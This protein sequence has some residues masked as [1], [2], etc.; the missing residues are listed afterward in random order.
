V[1]RLGAAGGFPTQT[2]GNLLS[3]TLFFAVA[4]SLTCAGLGPKFGNVRPFVVSC[5][6]YFCALI[7][8]SQAADLTFYALGACLVTYS[9][10]MGLP[11]AVARVA[12]LDEDGRY[13]VL[14]VPAI[15]IGAMIGPPI[16][17]VLVADDSLAPILGFGAGAV[18]LA[19]LLV[20]VAHRRQARV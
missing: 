19:L 20:G 11:F 4:G 5:G 9:F 8:L 2:V 14:T 18:L 10:G 6:I 3:A 12:E 15:G 17:G 7:L 13:V 1:E 16:A